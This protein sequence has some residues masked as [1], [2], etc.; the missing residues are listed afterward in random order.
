MTRDTRGRSETANL[1]ST[2]ITRTDHVGLTP[3]KVTVSVVVPVTYF[4]D[5]W[6]RNNPPAAGQ[7]PQQPT[8]AD[9]TTIEEAERQRIQTAVYN[10]IPHGQAQAAELVS[11]TAFT[12]IPVAAAPAPGVPA[13]AASWLAQYWSTLGMLGL[14]G[15]SLVFLRS[16]MNA[17]P[18]PQET[19]APQVFPRAAGVQDTATAAA[20]EKAEAS[21][22]SRL[23]RRVS[24]G[25][26][27]RDDLVELVRDDPDSAANILKGWIGS[28]N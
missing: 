27:L 28:V 8:A 15:V 16:M 9:L 22:K 4:E 20:A 3:E 6:R 1:P 13:L 10:Q 2:E 19:P 24:N 26:S 23:R 7:L 17:A 12:P 18:A 25:P 21:A 11:V 14:A 5:I